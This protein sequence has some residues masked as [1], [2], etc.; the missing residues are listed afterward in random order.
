MGGGGGQPKAGGLRIVVLIAS[1][2]ACLE[3]KLYP[4]LVRTCC[5]HCVL[6]A[7]HDGGRRDPAPSPPTLRPDGSYG[8]NR[9]KPH[10]PSERTPGKGA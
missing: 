3:P 2:L 8:T 5:A 6:Q 7:K 9:Y 1:L 4:T 10:V